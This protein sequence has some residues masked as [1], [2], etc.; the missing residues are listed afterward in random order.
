MSSPAESIATAFLAARRGVR[1]LAAFPGPLPQ[2]LAEAYAAQEAGIAL[3]GRPVRGWKVA[4]IAPALRAMAGADRLAGPIFEG[5]I[6]EL[7]AGGGTSVPVIEGG[8]AALEAEFAARFARDLEPGA[9][10]FTHD[11]I[12]DAL[13]G[14]HAGMEVASSPL[15][16][17]NEVGPF[18][19]ICDRGN[20][21]GAVL[22]P[23]LPSWRTAPLDQ[24]TS[25]MEIDG[26]VVGEGN[27]ARVAG[28][29]LA[30]LAFL[31]EQLASRGRRLRAGDIVLTGMTTGIHQVRPGA[32][33]RLVFG[34]VPACAVSVVAARAS[35]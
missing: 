24:M 3:D 4:G 17:L 16:T 25:R 2:T 31:A 15:P 21:M 32:Q 7:P 26:V 22:G 13:E 14:I 12:L 33:A 6:R 29:F 9:G 5:T 20:N 19:V 10:G 30:S 18:A 34:G 8:F 35:A 28:G 11:V 27:A 1:P 23:K